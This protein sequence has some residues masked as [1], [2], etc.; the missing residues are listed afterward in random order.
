MSVA[1][2]RGKTGV[3]LASSKG[4]FGTIEQL[5]RALHE[6][7]PAAVDAAGF[8]RIYAETPAAVLARRLEIGGPLSA[9]VA[10]CATGAHA[11]VVGRLMIMAGAADVV[12][13]GATESCIS[14]LLLAGYRNMGVLAADADSPAEACRPYDAGRDGFVLGEGSGI[15]ILESVEHA[16]ARG[17][18]VRAELK[19]GAIG[20]DIFHPTAPDPSGTAMS[21]TISAALR[22][23]HLRAE[24]I[25]YINTHGTATRLNDP[26]ETRAVR[27]A[28]G[29]AARRISLSSTKPMTGHLL[30][31]AGSVEFIIALMALEHGSVPP[32]IN[33]R[34]PDPECDLDYTPRAARRRAVRNVMSISCGFGGQIAV[35]IAGRTGK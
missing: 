1:G 17:A 19:G 33:L 30:G 27:T 23:A 29:E 21:E 26:S 20:E 12:I 3:C 5:C 14:P 4:S 7:G 15:V 31:A 28:F 35:L 10:A 2:R 25:D 8:W 18:R 13:A 22:G 24:E 16:A 34:R 32:T 6:V 9:P 11:I